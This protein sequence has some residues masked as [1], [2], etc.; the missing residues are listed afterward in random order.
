MIK[1]ANFLLV[2]IIS[3]V[4]STNAFAEWKKMNPIIAGGELTARYGHGM[5]FAS[6]DKVLCFGGSAYTNGNPE[7]WIYDLSDN[8]W[9]KHSITAIAGWNGTN[10]NMGISHVLGGDV[11][12]YGGQ[13]YSNYAYGMYTYD[14]EAIAWSEI[15]PD[16]GTGSAPNLFQNQICRLDQDRILIFGGKSTYYVYS[17]QTWVYDFGDNQLE[18]MTPTITGGTLHARCD[19]ALAYIGDDKALLFGGL[20][21]ST[22]YSDTWIY[23]ASDNEWTLMTPEVV[24]GNLSGRNETDICYIGG[25]RVLM[26]G[27]SVSNSYSANVNELWMYDLS[28]NRWTKLNG[29]GADGEPVIRRDSGIAYTGGGRVVMF[30]GWSYSSTYEYYNDTWIFQLPNFGA[31]TFRGESD[32]NGVSLT[33]SIPSEV[34]ATF[35]VYR[36]GELISGLIDQ[37][38]EENGLMTY[39]YDDTTVT[40]GTL[41]RYTVLE[42]C[43]DT[44]TESFYP[45]I[46]VPYCD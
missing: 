13:K 34:N 20:N 6:K 22:R 18:E 16:V 28:D 26:F 39:T 37:G 43:Q 11:L 19:A 32:S 45:E 3:L 5:T 4:W 36:N 40:S 46:K 8:T 41:N 25:D 7:T 29:S 21:G 42:I 15:Q 30:G 10:K 23:D 38:I 14:P 33:W 9:T 1:K 35:Y 12:T 27:G 31:D 24:D 44:E 2:L 17:D